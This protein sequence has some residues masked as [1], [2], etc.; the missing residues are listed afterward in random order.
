[1]NV[2]GYF[3]GALNQRELQGKATPNEES[4]AHD[5]KSEDALLRIVV[6]DGE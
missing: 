3:L 1:M 2:A 5:G 4:D 6:R